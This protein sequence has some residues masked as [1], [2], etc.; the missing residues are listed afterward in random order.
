M[1][2]LIGFDEDDALPLWSPKQHNR[3]YHEK[4]M[5]QIPTERQFTKQPPRIPSQTCH[6]HQNQG[7]SENLPREAEE[8]TIKCDLVSWMYSGTERDSREKTKEIGIKCE[9]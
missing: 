1:V 4:H 7:K 5:R 6:G 9:L 2:C 8:E 3:V